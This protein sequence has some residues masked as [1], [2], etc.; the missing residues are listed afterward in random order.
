MSRLRDILID[1]GS[2]P[3]FLILFVLS[4]LYAGVDYLKDRGEMSWKL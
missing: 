1:I 4:F 3:L 2:I